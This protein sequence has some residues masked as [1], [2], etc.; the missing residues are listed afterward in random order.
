MFFI[1][2]STLSSWNDCPRRESAKI[3]S[4]LI[5]SAGF[6]LHHEMKKIVGAVIGT[7]VHAGAGLALKG[8]MNGCVFKY[9][10]MEEAGI[11][12]FRDE[13]KD[14]IIYDDLSPN[15]NTCEKQ[16]Q[17]ISQVYWKKYYPFIEPLAIERSISAEINDDYTL[18]GHPDVITNTE[19][20][21]L[22]CG[23]NDKIHM[24]QLGGY[25]LLSRANQISIPDK[26]YID[27]IPRSDIRKPQKE[28][29]TFTYD[30]QEA[31]ALASS[32]IETI[33]YQHAKFLTNGCELSF[34]ANP[35]SILC[36]SKWC[37]A[38]GT[39]WCKMKRR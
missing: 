21:D 18:T 32:V 29:K 35:N 24:P 3:F 27:W 23:K 9:Q 14:G 11:T 2:A 38:Y 17:R 13:I 31:E 36:G 19:I 1:R 7:G 8:K 26:L 12:A 33:I 37:P 16:I 39:D 25:S 22:K 5:E 20:R 34:P 30:A 4:S 6:R 15:N 10:D 28:S